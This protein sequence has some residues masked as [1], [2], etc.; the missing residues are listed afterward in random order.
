MMSLE[1]ARGLKAVSAL[2]IPL[3]PLPAESGLTAV[4][5]QAELQEGA[6]GKVLICPN[7]SFTQH[8]ILS[9]PPTPSPAPF[10]PPTPRPN[11]CP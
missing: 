1:A 10:H 6:T 9:L 7:N 4:R 5:S 11:P 8:V 3:R 2:R